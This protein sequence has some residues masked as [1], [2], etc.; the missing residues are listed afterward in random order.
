MDKER[1]RLVGL[2]LEVWQ[3]NLMLL[4]KRKPGLSRL[5]LFIFTSLACILGWMIHSPRLTFYKDGIKMQ[6][7]HVN[8]RHLEKFARF[9]S[10]NIVSDF[11]VHENSV[12]LRLDDEE[13]PAWWLEVDIPKEVL[14]QLL[15]E[16]ENAPV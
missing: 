4:M 1:R 11:H 12:T 3:R 13:N 6:K 15:K 14:Q 9:D 2:S 16:L 8:G 7:L 5:L 10:R